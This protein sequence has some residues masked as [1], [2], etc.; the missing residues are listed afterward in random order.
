MMATAHRGQIPF[1]CDRSRLY[2][3]SRWFFGW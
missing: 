1:V 3:C 2:S